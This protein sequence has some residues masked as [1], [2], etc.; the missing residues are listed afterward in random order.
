MA[1]QREGEVDEEL[2]GAGVLQG[3]AEDHVA[4]HQLAE[5]DHR[6]PEHRL[7][8]V[9]VELAE[10]SEEHTS[11]L[12]SLMRISYAVCCLKK[13][14]NTLTNKRHKSP[15]LQHRLAINKI[16]ET[17]KKQLHTLI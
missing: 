7:R 6:Y 15:Q 2:A 8:R 10:R 17:N 1:E 5:R 11:E 12:Q 3:D 4:D 13:K 16:D 9:G 14:N